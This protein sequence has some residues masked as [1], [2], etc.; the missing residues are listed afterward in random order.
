MKLKAERCDHPT[1]HLTKSHL[2]MPHMNIE[3]LSISVAISRVGLYSVKLTGR[4]II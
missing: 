2:Q 4:G 1:A 3:F